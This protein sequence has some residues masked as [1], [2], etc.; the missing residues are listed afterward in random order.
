MKRLLL[1]LAVPVGLMGFLAPAQAQQNNASTT[2]NADVTII[3]AISITRTAHMNF[4]SVVAGSSLGTV[5]L[6]ANASPTRTASGGTTLGSAT[7]VSPAIFTIAGEPNNTYDITLPSTPVTI[8]DGTDNMTVDTF[9]SSPGGTGT[10]DG[11][12][13]QTLYVGATLNVGAAQPSGIY[14]G[15]FSVTVTYN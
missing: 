4:G 7:V 5:L 14:S 11:A 13:Q 6:P 10:L 2:A 1:A 15:S 8:T 3:Q 12:G 9:T